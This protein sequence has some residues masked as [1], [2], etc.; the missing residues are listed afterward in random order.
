ML[1]R[2]NQI[3][4]L[5]CMNAFTLSSTI[6][7]DLDGTLIDSLHDI[8]D[9]M[10]RALVANGFSP[11][12]YDAYRLFIGRGMKNLVKDALPKSAQTELQISQLYEALVVEYNKNLL[13]KTVLYEGIP[14]LLDH[15]ETVNISK[16]ILS[17]KSDLFTQ[18]I[19][20]K[21]LGKWSFQ[22]IIGTSEGG[23][24]KPDPT[25]ALNI[26]TKLQVQPDSVLFVGDSSIDMHTAK[27]AGMTA[28]GVTWGFRSRNELL[29]HGADYTIDKPMD[30]LNF[31]KIR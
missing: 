8:A 9:A 27:N 19:G 14:N 5:C 15:L 12:P 22:Y 3:D 13:E 26:C 29:E 30:L 25:E 10:N 31:L 20:E 18:K 4:Y 28:I 21:L 7:F 11:H 17:N 16:S 23:L 24:R 6:I 2:P 1:I